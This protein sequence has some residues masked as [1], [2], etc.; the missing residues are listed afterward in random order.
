MTWGRK[1]RMSCRMPRARFSQT[2]T[3]AFGQCPFEH[4][5]FVARAAGAV[6]LGNFEES[7]RA[8]AMIP[9]S[10]EPCGSLVP[11]SGAPAVRHGG[12]SRPASGKVC[13]PRRPEAE[14]PALQQ[15]LAV[16]PRADAADGVQSALKG[17]GGSN[18]TVSYR[19]KR[20]SRCSGP[21]PRASFSSNGFFFPSGI[22]TS[23]SECRVC[24]RAR[25]RLR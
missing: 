21:V 18:E 12:F 6:V 19:A 5:G 14:S 16:K 7:F 22:R 13:R 4:Q 1:R 24:A 3:V 11:S 23:P 9:G 15:S 20:Q 2:A 17:A 10:R 25:S 8:A